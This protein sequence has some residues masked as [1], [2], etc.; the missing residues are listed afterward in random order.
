MIFRNLLRAFNGVQQEATAP[1]LVRELEQTARC[2]DQTDLKDL[3]ESYKVHMTPATHERIAEY[4]ETVRPFRN[5]IPSSDWSCCLQTEDYAKAAQSILHYGYYTE[6]RL[7]DALSP[8][9]KTAYMCWEKHSQVLGLLT[10][11][12]M[13]WAGTKVFTKTAK[14]VHERVKSRAAQTAPSSGLCVM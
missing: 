5:H 14:Q 3:R 7:V 12:G 4:K 6:Q 10:I 11:G 8:L 13:A 9:N 2:D 1:A